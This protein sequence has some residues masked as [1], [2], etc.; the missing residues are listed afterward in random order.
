MRLVRD[1]RHIKNVNIHTLTHKIINTSRITIGASALGI[2]LLQ[3]YNKP[4]KEIV[5]PSKDY[6]TGS[7]LENKTN[8]ITYED[9][10]LGKCENIIEEKASKYYVRDEVVLTAIKHNIKENKD[11][12]KSENILNDNNEYESL[13]EQIDILCENISKNDEKYAYLGKNIYIDGIEGYVGEFLLTGYCPCASCCDKIDG[14]TASGAYATSNHTIAADSRF[15]FGTELVIDGQVYT[16]EDRGGAIKGNRID[17]FFDTHSEAL[18]FG[19]KYV[20]IYKH[21]NQNEKTLALKGSN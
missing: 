12:L 4:G 20:S 19:K 8:V 6:I 2:C 14:Q 3:G 9:I 7:A 21:I 10:F 5:I 18:D 15:D 1:N 11:I 13:D 17:V 16:V